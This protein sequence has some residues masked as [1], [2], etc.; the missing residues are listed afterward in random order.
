[1][2]GLAS[3]PRRPPTEEI[4]QNGLIYLALAPTVEPVAEIMGPTPPAPYE[5]PAE[6]PRF[7]TYL[8]RP[9]MIRSYSL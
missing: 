3:P 5:V 1:M 2:G 7:W 6:T 8:R 9:A 4:S